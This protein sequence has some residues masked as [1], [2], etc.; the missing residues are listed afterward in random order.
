MTGSLELDRRL[1]WITETRAE[2]DVTSIYRSTGSGQMR[3]R[4]RITQHLKAGI[5]R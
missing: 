1:A 3:V 2:I 4:T 5:A